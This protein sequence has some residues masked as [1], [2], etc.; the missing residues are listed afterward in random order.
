MAAG[1]A[2]ART[3]GKG[4]AAEDEGQRSHH[5]GPETQ[6]GGF[7]SRM[8]RVPAFVAVLLDGEF[9]DQDG[10]FRRQ[11]DQRHE[12]D[13][14]I[15]V[16]GDAAQPDG[17]D[18]P[19]HAER[20][21]GQHGERE[22]PAFILRGE[23]QEDHDQREHENERT[24]AA[25]QLFLIR[26]ARPRD[27]IPVR[28]HFPG[29]FLH[30]RH[31]LPGAVARGGAAHE[32]GGL[33]VVEALHGLR[34]GRGLHIDQGRQGDHLVPLVADV[35]FSQI[36]RAC[37]IILFRLRVD[38][39][40][41]PVQVEVVDVGGTERRLHRLKDIG[42]VHAEG[43][44]LL[45]VKLH[46]K[47]RRVDRKRRAHALQFGP[48]VR[49]SREL[50]RNVGKR[51]AS[52]A[53]TILEP[54]FK[55]AGVAHAADRRR[56]EGDERTLLQPEA[57]AVQLAGKIEGAV[58]GGLALV[59][60]LEG[61]EERRHV[62]LGRTAHGVHAGEAHHVRNQRIAHDGLVEL[63][64]HGGRAA[65]GRAVGH[66]HER[67]EVSLILIGDEPARNALKHAADA[68]EHKR[69]QPHG[70]QAAPEQHLDDADVFS[71]EPFKP[72]AEFA[73]EGIGLPMPRLEQ[74]G[75]QG[76]G[77]G[78]GH[79][80][81]YDHGHRDGDGELL[82]H[83]ARHAAG[84]GNGDEHGAQ[85]QHDGDDRARHFLHGLGGRLARRQPVADVPLHVFEHDDGVVDHDA[86]GKHKAEHGQGIDGEPKGI[87][88][89][90]RPHDGHGHGEAGDQRGAPVLEEQEH[91]E[92][93]QHH[94]LEQ[95]LHHLLDGNLHEGRG[96]VG[97]AVGHAHGER[98][99]QFLHLGLDHFGGG[100]GVRA[101]R[102]VN[103]DGHSF[104]AVVLAHKIVA[105]R[106]E[107]DGRHV[108]E[109]EDGAVRLRAE[110]DVAEL[111]RGGQAA[112]RGDLPRHAHAGRHGLGAHAPRREL[113]VLIPQGGGDVLRRDPKL[114]HDVR[115]EPHAHGVILRREVL[116]VTH[117]GKAFQLIDD[118]QQ[119]VVAE[120]DGVVPLIRRGQEDDLEHGGRLFEHRDAHA[121]H[122]LR[123]LR[124]RK[125]NPVVHVDGRLIR[126]SAH[127]EGDGQ[128]HASG[129]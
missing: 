63:F 88:A 99:G 43:A 76:G 116:G 50:L 14:K 5:D 122:F 75:A 118:V 27:G 126:I 101:R 2:R 4:H 100:E 73:E 62:G 56:I 24:A 22:R 20:H 29:H 41:P 66:G 69:E 104:E 87:H 9:H 95:R 49:R 127:I 96:I 90:E 52:L 28:Q 79:R 60:R 44:G 71:G 115:L 82:V 21:G 93:H 40:R 10:V 17:G 47:L 105:L 12:G 81:R 129:P 30:R 70:K 26:R 74:Q 57:H 38:A 39:E 121:L 124:Q 85:H 107:F 83:A 68:H 61:E 80:A 55:A 123:K 117:T 103:A 113:G 37:A 23:D 1:R 114:A 111:F 7:F 98:L 11:A 125:L 120:I 31:S 84:E 106:A 64:H 16:V 97:D 33:K 15:H 92:E 89:R 119:R 13:L 108:L 3:D 109:A 112:L 86:D 58:A 42:H 32:L 53:V 6:A 19:E 34:P 128:A 48:L 54:H 77:E 72:T 59:P 78:Q 25:D 18:G 94:R 8:R 65:D 45:A 91:H 110:D 102:K 51:L 46:K 35:H 67:D 36:F